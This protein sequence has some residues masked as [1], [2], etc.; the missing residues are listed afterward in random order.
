MS[1]KA[2]WIGLTNEELEKLEAARELEERVDLVVRK[3]MKGLS[4]EEESR[5][6]ILDAKVKELFFPVSKEQAKRAEDFAKQVGEAH[7]QV[8]DLLKE[9]DNY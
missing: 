6:Q 3:H 7:K 1:D 9:V 5:L 4:A 8:D 2:I